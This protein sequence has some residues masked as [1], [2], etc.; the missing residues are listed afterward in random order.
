MCKRFVNAVQFAAGMLGTS[1]DG[2]DLLWLEGLRIGFPSAYA[3]IRDHKSWFAWQ[4]T[5]DSETQNLDRDAIIDKGLEGM[6]G[7]HSQA[8]QSIIWRLF[9]IDGASPSEHALR[10]RDYFPHYFNYTRPKLASGWERGA[11]AAIASQL[12]D[13]T[14]AVEQF[15]ADETLEDEKFWRVWSRTL[16]FT[17]DSQCADLG[18][19]LAVVAANIPS[20][21]LAKLFQCVE[22]ANFEDSQGIVFRGCVESAGGIAPALRLLPYMGETMQRLA[23]V[24]ANPTRERFEVNQAEKA[25]RPI[26]SDTL[27]GLQ[28]VF[29]RKCTKDMVIVDDSEQAAQ[30]FAYATISNRGLMRTVIDKSYASGPDVLARLLKRTLDNIQT[31]EDLSLLMNWVVLRCGYP[32]NY[33]AL[34]GHA[35]ANLRSDSFSFLKHIEKQLSLVAGYSIEGEKYIPTL[36]FD[37]EG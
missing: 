32:S 11:Q 14:K 10:L 28:Q 1:L 31:D 4:S 22:Q 17:T 24:V 18:K 25:L 9:G 3:Q 8:A 36:A 2:L 13:T 19:S 30:M 21:Y 26:D 12:G 27:M 5:D 23:Q 29:L 16:G 6:S 20:K 34:E 35:Y 37:D 15:Q 33:T 7:L